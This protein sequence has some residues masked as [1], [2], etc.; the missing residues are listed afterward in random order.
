MKFLP[1]RSADAGAISPFDIWVSILLV[2]LTTSRS[3]AYPFNTRPQS[4]ALTS[5]EAISPVNLTG[6][7]NIYPVYPTVCLTPPTRGRHPGPLDLPQILSDCFWIINDLLR[8]DNLLFLDLVFHYTTFQDTHGNWHLSRWHHGQ[9]A[10]NVASIIRYQTQTLHLFNVILAANK[11]AKECL[12]DQRNPHGGTTHIGSPQR[13]FYVSVLGLD[14]NYQLSDSNMSLLSRADVSRRDLQHSGPRTTS[15]GSDN[16]NDPTVSLS[17]DINI[18]Q[19]A[20]SPHH[21]S[22]PSMGAKS[23]KPNLLVP[24]NDLSG[25]IITVPNHPVHCFDPHSVKLN[26][27]AGADCAVIIDHIILRYPNPMSPQ[28]FGYTPSA[29]INLSLPDNR[30]W[31]FGRCMIFVRNVDETRTDTFRMVDVAAAAQRIVDECVT[32]AKY[33]VGGTA[34]VGTAVEDFYVGLGAPGSPETHQTTDSATLL[35]LSMVDSGAHDGVG[36][37]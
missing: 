19:R 26:P 14:N 29:D 32:G 6:M 3:L 1:W 5:P 12:R 2:A 30:K 16:A 34:G 18:E 24:S 31:V 35:N 25:S 22:S 9:C 37:L 10:I 13:T 8:Y 11:I 7:E 4:L 23:L 33:A 28:T 20:L 15:T 27:T 17:P 21:G 36:T